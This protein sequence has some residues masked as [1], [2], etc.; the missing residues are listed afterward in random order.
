[1][2]TL[3]GDPQ[4]RSLTSS[5]LRSK[6]KE[7]VGEDSSMIRSERAVEIGFVT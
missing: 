3:F 2:H 6:N 4:N 7:K 5:L 1:M